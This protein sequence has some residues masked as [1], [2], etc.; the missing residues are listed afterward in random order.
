MQGADGTGGSDRLTGWKDISG[1]LGKSVSAAQRW[2]RE[3]GLPVHR[4]RTGTGQSVYASKTEIDQW[5]LTADLSKQTDEP[6]GAVEDSDAAPSTDTPADVPMQP[7]APRM[8]AWPNSTPARVALVLVAVALLTA[9]VGGGYVLGRPRAVDYARAVLTLTGQSLEARLPNGERLWVHDFGR[10]V[11]VFQRERWLKWQESTS[12]ADV[13]LDADG[14]V[15]RVVPVRFSIGGQN[16][17]DSD[18]LYAFRA[19]GRLLWSVTA[20]DAVTCGGQRYEGPWQISAVAVS[21]GPGPRRV[22]V[23]FI[24]HTWW[25]SLVMEIAPDGAQT[26]RYVQAG[27]VMSLTEWARPDGTHLVAG[28]VLNE[29]RRPSIVVLRT[30][31]APTVSPARAAEFSC[32]LPGAQSPLH[33]TTVAPFEVPTAR[34][35]PYVMTDRLQ[36]LGDSLRFEFESVAVG[37]LAPSGR[38]DSLAPLDAYLQA[39]QPLHTLQVLSHGV[40]YCPELRTP[41]AVSQWTPADGWREYGVEFKGVGITLE[42]TA[43]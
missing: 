34:G 22:W 25:P 16:R 43:P 3:V 19:S 2:E 42:T 8:T 29:E 18:G 7:S 9:A 12:V 13:D 35:V 4:V 23:A 33:V 6:Q 28:G 24:H 36:V 5:L 40:D 27:W 1:Y 15:E 39:H 21:R 11:G 38:I 31:G 10:P 20:P 26:L 17:L 14:E 32:E 41:K 30:D 37:S